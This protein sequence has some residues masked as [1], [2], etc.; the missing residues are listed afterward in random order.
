MEKILVTGGAGFIGSHLIKSLKKDGYQVLDD[1]FKCK[2]WIL[3]A[4]LMGSSD[5]KANLDNNFLSTI[6]FVTSTKKFPRKI[7]YISSIDIYSPDTYYASAKL[8]TEIFLRV[9]C[10]ENNIKLII[11][12]PSQIYGPGD[13]GKKVIPKFIEA[14]K[15]NKI[16]ELFDGGLARRRYLYVSDL[17]D[18]IKKVI[19]KDVEG[20]FDIV[21]KE[22]VR[23]KDVVGILEKEIGKKARQRL[24][25]NP[26]ISF[27][28]GIR[29]TLGKND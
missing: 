29:L 13:K 28:K 2:T 10:K 12:R 15:K 8:A 4:G 27:R 21:G 5:L 23:I 22:A 26:R 17:A 25:F 6:N 20:T 18:L 7:I 9:F 19:K 16:I 11:F 14:I 1:R 3:I 24:D